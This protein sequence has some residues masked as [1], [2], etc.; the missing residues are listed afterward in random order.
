MSLALNAS[1]SPKALAAIASTVAQVANST[2]DLVRS[3]TKA[4]TKLDRYMDRSLKTQEYIYRKE[5]RSFLKN[6]VREAAAEQAEADMKVEEFCKQSDKHRQLFVE[7]YGEFEELF[8]SELGLTPSSTNSETSAL[9][10]V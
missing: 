4:V 1:R 3:G 10:A 6:L 7:S 8:A 9:K 5:E 2:G